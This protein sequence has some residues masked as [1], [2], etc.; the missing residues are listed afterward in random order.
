MGAYDGAEACELFGLFLLNEIVEGDI[1]LKKEILAYK[2]MM[3]L[4]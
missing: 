2:E 3:A 4:G 1:G